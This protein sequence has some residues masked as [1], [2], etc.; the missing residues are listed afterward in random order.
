[1]ADETLQF[2]ELRHQV[3]EADRATR[4][5]EHAVTVLTHAEPDELAADRAQ[6][7]R[8]AAVVAAQAAAE[9]FV[10]CGW[11][12]AAHAAEQHGLLDRGDR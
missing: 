8:G 9:L 10:T 12:E 6:R 1:M 7:L 3:A 11:L 4:L 5:L 2:P